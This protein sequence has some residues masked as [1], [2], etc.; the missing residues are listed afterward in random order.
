MDSLTE[1]T[2]FD[3]LRRHGKNPEHLY[4]DLH[5]DVRHGRGQWNLFRINMKTCEE[6]GDAIEEVDQ[7]IIACTYSDGRLVE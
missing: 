3:L 1:S 6:I 4:H 7:G 2:L 5:K